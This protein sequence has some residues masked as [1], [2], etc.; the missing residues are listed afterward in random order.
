MSGATVT[1]L[2]RP[3]A[4]VELE[5]RIVGAA[6]ALGLT[7]SD[8]EALGIAAEDFTAPLHRK[9]WAIART[10][11]TKKLEVSA[12]TVASAGR[13]GQWFTASE[14]ADVERLALTSLLGR[15]EFRQVAADFRLGVHRA[16]TIAA[17]EQQ[18]QQLRTGAFNPARSAAALEAIAH[19]L[20]RDTAPDEDATGDVIEL[21][22]DW[23]DNERTNKSRLLPTRILALD[24]EYGGLP[25]GLTVFAA[26]PGVGKT[27]V[28]DSMIRAQLEADPEL[29]LGFFGL[30]DGTAHI[31]RRWMA[32]ETGMLLREVGWKKR[33]EE[34]RV[35]SEAAAEKFRPLLQRLHVY[36]HDTITAPELVARIASMRARYGI[37]AAY[38][39]NLTEV[40]FTAQR[41]GR[42]FQEREHQQVAELGRQLRNFGLRE[43][44]PIGLI[45]HT[46]GALKVGDIPSPQDLAGGQALG[47]RVRLF[48][49]MWAKGD[50]IRATVDKA[51]EL[52]PRGV[53]I[54][55][56]RF[57]EAGLI[58]PNNGSKINLAQERA[59]EK[60][61]K[62]RNDAAQREALAA[63]R[64]AKKAAAEAAAKEAAE[65]LKTPDDPQAALALEAEKQRAV[66]KPSGWG[67]RWA[68]KPE[69]DE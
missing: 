54:E 31:A 27:A 56:A 21:L 58:D 16:R 45:A 47:R 22:Y 10:K 7:L 41:Q 46:I 52:G 59:A 57:A 51:N 61:E 38:V 3:V 30:E 43:S 17:L 32:H 68:S 20:Q 60:A 29:H 2:P 8:F 48:I 62:V 6:L 64:R 65:K 24:A 4:G 25:P 9:A 34:Q 26:A 28:M 37:A 69:A 66:E 42:D 67:M 13:A 35:A 5:A 49:G 14:G 39:D 19:Q 12:A 33:T 15:E 11:A 23:D 55:F 63:E 36:R 53:T 1:Q 44:M 18:L 40:D 50:A